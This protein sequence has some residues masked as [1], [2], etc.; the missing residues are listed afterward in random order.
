MNTTVEQTILD[1]LNQTRVNGFPLLKYIG[2][3]TAQFRHNTCIIS[4]Q[5]NPKGITAIEVEYIEALDTYTIRYY[6]GNQI[7]T[8]HDDIYFDNFDSIARELGVL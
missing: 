4:V 3:K 7:I 2:T 5:E 1:Q 8:E 6:K